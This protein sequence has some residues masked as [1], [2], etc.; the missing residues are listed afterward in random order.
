MMNMIL[1]LLAAASQLN[2]ETTQPSQQHIPSASATVTIPASARA[3]DFQQAFEN[4]RA[5]KAAGK[6]Y[7][8]LA[9]G[10]TINNIIDMQLM[11][12]ST[13]ALFRYTSNQGVRYQVVK[14]ED[15]RNLRY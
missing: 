11:S 15:I 5:E 7:F 6:L 9:D 12:N 13:I 10:S 8:E 4:L 1:F 3:L 2:A 14:V